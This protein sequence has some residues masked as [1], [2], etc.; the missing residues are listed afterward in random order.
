MALRFNFVTILDSGKLALSGRPKIKEVKKLIPAGCTH[1]VTILAAKGEQAHRIGEAVESC[2]MEWNWL[3]V[4]HAT[5]LSAEE[6]I[7]FKLCVDRIHKKILSNEN[8][9]VHCSAGLHRTGMF[10]YALL[11]KGGIDHE[12]TLEIIHEIRTDTLDALEEKY[13]ETARTLYQS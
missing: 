3:K 8:V 2:G 4:S 6:E 11:R 10:A 5:G 9:L 13:I 7:N 12:Q 1:V